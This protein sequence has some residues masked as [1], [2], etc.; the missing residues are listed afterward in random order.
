MSSVKFL[1]RKGLIFGWMS[2]VLAIR[3]VLLGW[4]TQVEEVMNCPSMKTKL[5]E[6]VY[7]ETIDG[8]DC[9]YLIGILNV[10]KV[11]NTK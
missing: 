2:S 11:W 6:T 7:R 8:R 4:L 3:L 10:M 5:K 9:M 1:N